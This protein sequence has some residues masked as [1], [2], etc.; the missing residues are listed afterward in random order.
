MVTYLLSCMNHIYYIIIFIVIS[1]TNIHG[2]LLKGLELA[3]L[4]RKLTGP[5]NEENKPEPIM[6]FLTDGESNVGE[7]D[8]EKIVGIVT[9]KNG[10]DGVSIFALAFG[11]YANSQFLKKLALRNSGFARKIYEASDSALQ[12][13]DFYRV[14]SSPL[15]AKVTFNYP[16]DQVEEGTLSQTNF[17]TYFSGSELVVAG[18]L[19]SSELTGHL[20]A[21]SSNGTTSIPFGPLRVV[22]FPDWELAAHHRP[23]RNY[24]DA[25]FME[26]LW[27]Y[28]TIQQLL[29]KETAETL[30]GTNVTSPSKN[31]A[32]DLALKVR[33]P[34]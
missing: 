31:K 4:G 20:T 25:G 23:E 29:E 19:K 9:D 24:S 16:E 26:R 13:R 2:A 18:K 10:A 15:L 1:G 6:I 30:E 7:S 28:L 32:L 12:L 34:F 33:L 5:D 8:P 14:V 17:S 21:K 22:P 27:A 11:D 3:H